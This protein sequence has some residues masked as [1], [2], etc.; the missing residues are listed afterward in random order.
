M[1]GVEDQ[2]IRPARSSNSFS[3]DRHASRATHLTD[4]LYLQYGRCFLISVLY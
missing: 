1:C 3:R 4:T 2:G